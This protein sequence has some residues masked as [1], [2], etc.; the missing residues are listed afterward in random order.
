MRHAVLEAG[1]FDCSEA[2]ERK[3]AGVEFRREQGSS[4]FRTTLSVLIS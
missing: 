2:V 1:E 4:T 3:G